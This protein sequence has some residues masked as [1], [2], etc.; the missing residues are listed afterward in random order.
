[1][2]GN[3]TEAKTRCQNGQ[4]FFAPGLVPP[5]SA[6]KSGGPIRRVR[7]ILLSIFWVS[8]FRAGQIGARRFVAEFAHVGA[9]GI[10][11]APRG[12]EGSAVIFGFDRDASGKAVDRDQRRI[13]R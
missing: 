3:G 12:T 13:E 8:S 10:G 1:M 4:A 6:Q 11:S 2:R 9:A 5:A 7:R